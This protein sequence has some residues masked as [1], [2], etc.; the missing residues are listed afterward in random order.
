M[1][2]LEGKENIWDLF[3]V[4]IS[5]SLML[6]CPNVHINGE[7]PIFLKSHLMRLGFL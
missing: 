2:G 5:G 1:W 6:G 7:F 4:R 3:D